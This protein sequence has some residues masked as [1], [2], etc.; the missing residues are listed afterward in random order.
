M[1]RTLGVKV[2]YWKD[3]VRHL[4]G[5]SDNPAMIGSLEGV[6]S[7]LYNIGDPF[8]GDGMLTRIYNYQ[9]SK[10]Q[11]LQNQH[12]GLSYFEKIITNS[13]SIPDQKVLLPNVSLSLQNLIT[14]GGLIQETNTSHNIPPANDKLKNS[15]W[16]TNFTKTFAASM[17]NSVESFAFT[18]WRLFCD[19][20]K[21]IVKN[22]NLISSA[23]SKWLERKL[24][25]ISTLDNNNFGNDL[26]NFH[27]K[28]KFNNF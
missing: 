11:T 2:V 23:D 21:V 1:A 3:D 17:E 13:L 14:L 10:K 27:N 5:F 28:T 12:C 24:P 26:Y 6:H 20:A 8:Q 7:T 25:T 15:Y 22:R 19:I 16:I 4:W 9:D 18:Q